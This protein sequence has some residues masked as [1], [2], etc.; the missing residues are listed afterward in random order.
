V[1]VRGYLNGN[2]P[3]EIA[4]KL[5]AV[6]HGETIELQAGRQEAALAPGVLA[7]FAGTYELVPGVNILIALAGHRLPAKPASQPTFPVL[8]EPE[9]M[10]FLKAVAAQIE[11]FRDSAGTVAH[12]VL[13][14]NG[15][16]RKTLRIGSKTKGPP[17]R[18]EMEIPV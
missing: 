3:G 14:R 4:G 15:R 16:D 13:H 2:A 17:P 12:L 11:S 10:H 6:A 18:K 7:Q 8:P 5:T 1:V 9:T